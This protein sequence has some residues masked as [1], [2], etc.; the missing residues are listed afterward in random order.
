MGR[1]PP[2]ESPGD[3]IKHIVPRDK[4]PQLH[5]VA[6]S[7]WLNALLAPSVFVPISC[8][9]R[10]SSSIPWE[11]AVKA[12]GLALMGRRM[13]PAERAK[14][15]T[16]AAMEAGRPHREVPPGAM[17]ERG[18]TR[19][20]RGDDRRARVAAKA[21]PK[22]TCFRSSMRSTDRFG[23]R[24][25]FRNQDDSRGRGR[26]R[27]DVSRSRRRGRSQVQSPSEVRGQEAESREGSRASSEA[28]GG[29]QGKRE[30]KKR[31]NFLARMRP[32]V[33]LMMD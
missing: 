27:R 5:F 19:R 32:E 18:R 23:G 33:N 29:V 25:D 21:K 10:P 31:L 30:R 24:D 12:R 1:V 26:R 4:I 15:S 13:V 28:S 16:G 3:K 11:R 8:M 14:S 22:W 6:W 9:L 2:L 17:R 7:A 20:R